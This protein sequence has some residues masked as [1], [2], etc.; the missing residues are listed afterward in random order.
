M[1]EHINEEEVTRYTKSPISEAEMQI[2]LE[3]IRNKV[4]AK[5]NKW[6]N[7]L[8]FSTYTTPNIIRLEGEKW[9]EGG[10][11]WIIDRGIKKNFTATQDARMPHWCP[12]CSI[13]MNHR[14]DRKFYFLRGHCFNCNIAFEQKMRND[15]TWELFEKRMI[16]ENEKAFLKDKIQEHL[17]YIR[18][19]KVP[20]IH[21]ENGGW[22]EL[23]PLSAFTELFETLE[24]DVDKML[25]RLDKIREIEEEEANEQSINQGQI[26]Q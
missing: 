12:K 4:S 23:A 25:K 6:S 18:T 26:I 21:F 10:K 24:A 7:K 19:F 16:R 2:K 22:E 13:S 14:F 1:S 5:M 20:Q 17:D 3:E 15:G 8:V 9:S 11:T